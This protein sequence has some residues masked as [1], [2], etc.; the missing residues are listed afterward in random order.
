[1][2]TKYLAHYS[3]DLDKKYGLPTLKKY[4][5]PDADHV[6][7]AI[8]F[9]NYVDPEHEKE[10]ANSILKRM[11][12]YGMSFDDFTVGEENRFSKYIPSK[13]EL[14]HHG[15]EGQKWGHTNGPPY[16]LDFE[17]HSLAE[18]RALKKDL[19]WIKK[20]EKKIKKKAYKESKKVLDR[21][22]KRLSKQYGLNKNGKYSAFYINNFNR[23][24]ADLMN[25]KVSDITA[26]SGRTVRFVAKRGEIGVYTA[27]ADQGYDMSQVKNGVWNSGRIAY[28]KDSINKVDVNG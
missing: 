22:A 27:L 10:L 28:K 16:P 7:S 20:N 26:P 21:Y 3:D 14:S 15:I 17:A 11:R 9:F 1:M 18:K 12:E 4:P 2:K 5:M 8:K 25:E 19:K 23:S 24:M 6:R 13:K